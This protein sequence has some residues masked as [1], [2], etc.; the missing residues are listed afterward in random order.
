MNRWVCPLKRPGWGT[1]TN[2]HTQSPDNVVRNYAVILRPGPTHPLNTMDISIFYSQPN[3]LDSETQAD[4]ILTK[5]WT[6]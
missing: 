2:Q 1:P 5:L 4:Q 6:Q 3:V